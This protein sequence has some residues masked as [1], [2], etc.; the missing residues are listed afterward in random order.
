MVD[1]KFKK[2][3]YCPTQVGCNNLIIINWIPAKKYIIFQFAKLN[4]IRG[5][6]KKKWNSSKAKVQ[7]YNQ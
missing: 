6:M 1:S 4:C 2:L 5:T 3:I 7:K